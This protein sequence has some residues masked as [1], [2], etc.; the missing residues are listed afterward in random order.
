MN[1]K[2]KLHQ[3]RLSEWAVR[4]SDQKA[5]GLTVQPV[6]REKRNLHPQVQLPEAPIQGRGRRRHTAG[7]RSAFRSRISSVPRTRHVPARRTRK[8]SLSLG[9]LLLRPPYY[10]AFTIQL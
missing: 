7:H 8:A 3:A 2:Q 4:F 5:S 9:I 10:L 6:V 1:A